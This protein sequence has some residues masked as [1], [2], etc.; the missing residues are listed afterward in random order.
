[1]LAAHQ[2]LSEA[3]PLA[4]RCH[5]PYYLPV[6]KIDR[7]MMLIDA[8]DWPAAIRFAAKFPRLGAEKHAITTAASALLSPRFYQSLGQSPDVIVAEGV[9]ALRRRYP[10]RL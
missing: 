1:M 4:F 8:G 10:C 5:S 7:L 2:V 3:S 6:R 9:A